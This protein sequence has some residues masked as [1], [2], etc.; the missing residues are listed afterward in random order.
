MQPYVEAGKMKG[1]ALLTQKR[2]SFAA[3]WPII[4]DSGLAIEA[5]LWVGLF[6]PAGTTAAIV[7]RLDAEVSRILEQQDFRKRL[8]DLGTDPSPL[9]QAAFVARIASDADRY[10]KIIAQA[11]IQIQ[12]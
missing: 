11:G 1:L 10:A 2:P 4:S 12:H 8:N 6:A 5:A 3:E 9:S 7:N